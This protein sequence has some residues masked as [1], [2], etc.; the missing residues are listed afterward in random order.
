MSIKQEI[1]CIL[2]FFLIMIV[3]SV[4]IAWHK[5]HINER[6][7]DT[8]SSLRSDTC[9]LCMG[10]VSSYRAGVLPYQIR[11]SERKRRL[12][13]QIKSGHIKPPKTHYEAW[14]DDYMGR[15]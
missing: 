14:E 4:A 15:S 8:I 11:R 5:G 12:L 1:L 10:L 13:E 6:F 7:I 2:L 9:V 3:V